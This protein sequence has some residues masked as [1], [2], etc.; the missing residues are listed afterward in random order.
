MMSYD[1]LYINCLSF[2]IFLLIYPLISMSPSHISHLM[3]WILFVLYCIACLNSHSTSYDNITKSPIS[4]TDISELHE[5]HPEIVHISE[6]SAELEYISNFSY[7]DANNGNQ[8]FIASTEYGFI[9]ISDNVHDMALM[10]VYKTKMCF[11]QMGVGM[12]MCQ[13]TSHSN[14]SLNQFNK[15][16]L[17]SSNIY[18]YMKSFAYKL[19]QLL[20]LFQKATEKWNLITFQPYIIFCCLQRH[21]SVSKKCKIILMSLIRSFCNRHDYIMYLKAILCMYLLTNLIFIDCCIYCLSVILNQ[22]VNNNAHFSIFKHICF[23]Q[24]YKYNKQNETSSKVDSDKNWI[25]HNDVGGGKKPCFTYDLLQQYISPISNMQYNA[26]SSFTFLSHCHKSIAVDL[27]K[28]NYKYIFAQL[29]LSILL[30]LLSQSDMK[31][32][33]KLHNLK[34]PYRATVTQLTYF[35]ENHYCNYCETYASVFEKFEKQSKT[36]QN[37]LHY[38]KQKVKHVHDKSNPNI[39]PDFPPMPPSYQLQEHIIRD[40]CEDCSSKNILESGCAVC[41]QLKPCKHLSVLSTTRCNLQILSRTGSGITRKER[42]KDTAPIEELPG[43][44][45][46]STCSNICITCEDS[47]WKRQTPKY[48]LAKGFWLG[49]IPSQLQNLTFAEQLL[50]ARVRHNKCIVRVSS[51]MHKMKAN[52]IAFENPTPKIYKAL[53]PSIDELDDVLAFIFTGPC[54]P[55]EKELK[56]TPLLVRRH[57]VCSALEWLKLN[58]IDYYDLDISYD[59]LQEYPENGCP[60]VVV[61]R[62]ADSNKN[63]EST[64]AF[65][66]DY[67][68]GTEDGP[69][70]F[71]V[72]GITGEELEINN[73]KALIARATKHLMEDNGGVLAIGH[74]E[75]PQSIYHNSK[76][77]PMMFPHLFPYGLGGIGSTDSKIVRISEMMHKRQLLMYHDKRF[78]CD[79][80]FPLVAFNHEQM[81]KCTTGGFLLTKRGNFDKIADRLMNIDIGVLS[82]LSQRLAKGE[83]VKPETDAEKNCYQVISDLDHVAHNVQGSVTSK[84]YMRNEIWSL[85][86]YLGAP[87]WFITFAPADNKHPICLYYANTKEW[88]YPQLYTSKECYNLI[89]NNPV[90]GARFFHFM[91]EMFIKHVLG[92]GSNHAGLYGD[93]SGY[94]GT[95]EQQGRLTLHL[96]L[97]LW[98]SGSLTPQEIRDK[99]MD[100][101]SDFQKRLVEYLESLCVGQF[102]TGSKSEVSANVSAA[103]EHDN[104]IDPTYTLP[105]VPAYCSRCKGHCTFQHVEQTRWWEKFKTCVDDILLRSNIH[106]HKIDQNGKDKSYCLN[107]NGQCKRRFPRETFE[108][109]LVEP[110]TGALNL[111]KGE[112]WMNTVTPLLTYLLRCNSDVTSLLSGTAIKAVVAYVTDYITKQSL[113][114]YSIFDVIKS[115]FDRN[116]EMLGGNLTRKEKV[117]KLFTQIVNS[118]TAKMEIGSPMASLYVLGNPDHYTNYEFIPFYWRPY[119]KWITD[120][121]EDTSNEYDNP[122]NVPDNVVITK[123]NGSLVG[124]SQITDYIFRPTIYEDI[125]LYDWIRFAKKERIKKIKNKNKNEDDNDSTVESDNTS[126]INDDVRKR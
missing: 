77:Y 121:F 53:P 98:I 86:S 105:E 12:C 58:H 49:N 4:I 39:N 64:S 61:Y 60:V 96:H 122:D 56:R 10:G 71:V 89:A 6:L 26:N 78:Q 20:V 44:V 120:G 113:K 91:T 2:L 100:V 62:H 25:L 7:S 102:M 52:A 69:C 66:Q 101:N 114:T 123:I 14:N 125:N 32:I 95:V 29:P 41:G 9:F 79:P 85:I 99:I 31:N 45:L 21:I 63:A 22:Y 110:K 112:P 75:H 33:S 111:K 24:C 57:K 88:L 46:D 23:N 103:S 19:Y 106:S 38:M 108:Q 30:P 74:G 76:L 81:K 28:Q 93:T 72:N 1:R 109:T 13:T 83:H 70:P 80:Y 59:N 50:I 73:P 15:L 119:I 97:L 16:Q 27:C 107:A 94:Y 35:L 48:A 5:I 90:A 118:L 116:S 68:D 40:C 51:G 124:L 34:L 36:K 54:K 42:T 82:D 84:R 126:Y 3:F 67:E 87:S 11:A 104:Y 92:V 55:T 37:E 65:D 117:R 43:P 17:L 18:M 8:S 115:I 47:L